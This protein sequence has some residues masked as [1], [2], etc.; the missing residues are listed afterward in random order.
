MECLNT[1]KRT[2]KRAKQSE[3]QVNRYSTGGF[4]TR[5]SLCYI[6]VPVQQKVGADCDECMRIHDVGI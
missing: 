5:Q 4:V 3:W 6:E 1:K 2:S